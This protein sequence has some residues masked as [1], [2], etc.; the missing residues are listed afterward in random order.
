MSNRITSG[1]PLRFAALVLSLTVAMAA[2]R[3]DSSFDDGMALRAKAV[4]AAEFQ[5]VI[6]KL[7]TSAA[8]GNGKA[9]IALGDIYGDPSTPVFDEAVAIS[10]YKVAKDMGQLAQSYRGIATLY[11]STEGAYHDSEAALQNFELAAALGDT[12]AASAASDMYTHGEGARADEQKAAYFFKRAIA[13][14]AVTDAAAKLADLYRSPEG[15][16]F[17][18][19]EA[20]RLYKLAF[21]AGDSYSLIALGDIHADGEAG[22]PD[23]DAAKEYF[24]LARTAGRAREA[25]RRLASIYR[26]PQGKLHEPATAWRLYES[27]AAGGDSYALLALADMRVN[28]EAGPADPVAAMQYYIKARDAGLGKDA[29]RGMAAI[30]RTAT[31]PLHDIEAAIKNYEL[32]AS[33]GDSASL[34]DIGDIYFY[35]EGVAADHARAKANYEKAQSQ[36]L[37]KETSRRLALIYQMRS[38]IFYDPAR[39]EELFERSAALGDARS[40][41]SLADLYSAGGAFL[42]NEERAKPFLDK[43]I[44]SGLV[45][46]ATRK[47]AALY[48]S[49]DGAL[50]DPAMAVKLYMKAADLGDTASMTALGEM[51]AHGEYSGQ[52]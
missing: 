21:S 1:Y 42:L 27:A 24:E 30:Q 36:G 5:T 4:T 32:A 39:A 20:V 44:A 31:G 23:E 13:A 37:Q 34:V 40:L 19:A 51:Y 47:L 6:R 15:S 25:D 45:A 33:L 12:A 35:G 29:A 38:S 43:A 26:S 28:G 22:L 11:R 16:L 14:G 52:P 48:R 18:I 2:A 8:A 41:I 9:M 3:A 50:H 7:Q 10:F 17:D 46:D 49:P